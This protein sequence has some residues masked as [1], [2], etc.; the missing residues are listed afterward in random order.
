MN[1]HAANFNL[2]VL[3]SPLLFRKFFA[4]ISP[5]RVLPY[6]EEL[7]FNIFQAPQ[8]ILITVSTTAA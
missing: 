5:Y 2:S 8:P 7:F 6:I 1:L 4:F 3:F